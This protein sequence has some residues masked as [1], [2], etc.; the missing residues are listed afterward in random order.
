MTTS[1]L[2]SRAGQAILEQIGNR[3][4]GF[5]P[6]LMADIVDQNGGIASVS[7]F[8]R[9][10]PTYERI[11]KEWG[12]IRT[13]LVACITS[14]LTGCPYCTYGH[15]YALQLHYFRIN[16]DVMPY[17]ER[18][19]EAWCSLDDE[20]VVDNYRRLLEE[21]EL[22]GELPILDRVV[23]LRNGEAASDT[24]DD[25]NIEHLL[26]MFKFLNG[27]GIAADTETDQAHDPINKDR[28]LRDAYAARRAA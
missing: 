27:C 12:P 16:G 11:L 15:A 1:P 13:H 19:L 4:W 24:P 17:D 20:I 14:T 8:A 6:N 3:L 18:D 5:K 21:S 2:T 22:D 23:E 7:W 26:T 28:P 9:N 10:M 25:K